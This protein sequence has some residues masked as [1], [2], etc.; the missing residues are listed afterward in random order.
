MIQ[1][2][3]MNKLSFEIKVAAHLSKKNNRPI[4][5]NRHTGRAFIGKNPALAM[6]ETKLEN[7]FRKQWQL[8]CDSLKRDYSPIGFPIHIKMIFFMDNF[9]NKSGSVNKKMPD[10]SNL[11]E[12]PQDSL[13]KAGVIEDDRLV[14][15]H[16]GSRRLP[17]HENILLIEI[18]RFEEDL[19]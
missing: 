6:Q 10:L 19:K 7:E 4:F 17:W 15:S 12:L 8:Y 18:S 5:K 13:Q 1:L 14:Y 11:Y 16:D 9:Y 2:K 3:K